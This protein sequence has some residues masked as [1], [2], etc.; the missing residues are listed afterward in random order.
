M[1]AGIIGAGTM[2]AG[3]AQVFAANGYQTVLCDVDEA[4]SA[5]GKSTIE[6]SLNKLVLKGKMEQSVCDGILARIAK[7]ANHC[8]VFE[9]V[10]HPSDTSDEHM[11]YRGTPYHDFI[12][13]R[14][15]LEKL[16]LRAGFKRIEYGGLSIPPGDR[17]HRIILKAYK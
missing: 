14:P 7:K 3:I 1:K 8:F 4:L 15:L 2:G 10:V 11:H 13:T 5:K 9:G 6:K 16:L 12:P 17:S